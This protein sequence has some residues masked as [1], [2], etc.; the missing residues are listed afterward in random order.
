M[1]SQYISNV[2]SSTSHAVAVP[3]RRPS[4]GTEVNVINW[5]DSK[6]QFTL[7]AQLAL[8][9]KVEINGGENDTHDKT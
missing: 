2:L 5:K 3:V 1:E 4:T 6:H 9:V 7:A 8:E